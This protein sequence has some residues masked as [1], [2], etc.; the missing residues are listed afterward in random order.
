[1]LITVNIIMCMLLI[2]Q[3]PTVSLLMVLR[4]RQYFLL[5]NTLSPLH[6]L[7]ST[8]EERESGSKSVSSGKKKRKRVKRLKSKMYT[9]DDGAMGEDVYSILYS[10][11]LCL[12]HPHCVNCCV[13]ETPPNVVNQVRYRCLGTRRV[14]LSGVV[15]QC[16]SPQAYVCNKLRQLCDKTTFNV[17]KF[18]SCND[19][20]S[21]EECSYAVSQISMART[22]LLI[23]LEETFH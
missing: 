18:H 14:S 4:Q 5:I 8:Q 7:E 23:A 16:H 1:M 2:S 22:K 6:V 21:M 11:C 20:E 13:C 19:R 9:T 17:L 10:I 12:K 3:P 15:E